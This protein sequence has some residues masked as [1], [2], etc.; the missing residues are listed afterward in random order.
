MLKKGLMKRKEIVNLFVISYTALKNREDAYE[1]SG[2]KW[3][4]SKTTKRWKKPDASKNLTNK[5]KELLKETI[6]CEP[7]MLW[8]LFA[9]LWLWTI[10]LITMAIKELFDKELKYWKV[11]K[12]L[13]ELWL[14]N[15]NPIFKAYQQNPE[16]VLKRVEE[17][18]PAI[19][20]E[21]KMEDR[22]IFYGDEAWFKTC[23]NKGKTRAPRGETPTVFATW[24]RFWVNAISIV[25]NRWELRFMV[26]E[27]SF[28]WDTLLQFLKRLVKNTDQKYTL[29]L[30]WHP[31]HKSKKVNAYLESIDHQVKIYFLPW[32]SPELN[33]GEQ[34][35]YHTK[36]NLKGR[37]IANK[38][39]LIDRVKKE[40]FRLQKQKDKVATF[41]EHP[42]I[43]KI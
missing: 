31:T 33:P 1:K 2:M 32:Y 28:T 26:Y 20:E 37:R 3:L 30:D 27:W 7:R 12:L 22:E 35:R 25:S 42:K 5:E 38:Q 17:D 43:P 9:D 39:E 19:H 34:V 21:A 23:D 13:V 4:R 29:I 10:E 8:W 15:Q 40:L 11:H 14:T 16:K 36:I 18:L 41:F 6:K 24:H